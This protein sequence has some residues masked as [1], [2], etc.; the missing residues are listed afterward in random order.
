MSRSW[1]RQRERGTPGAL[2]L[3]RWIALHLGRTSARLLLFP[4]TLFFLAVAAPQR[5]ASRG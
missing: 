3:I 5:R 4:I 1:R 2:R